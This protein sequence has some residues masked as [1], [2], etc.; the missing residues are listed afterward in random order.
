MNT[1]MTLKTLVTLAAAALGAGASALVTDPSYE[2]QPLDTW[3]NVLGNWI[4]NTWGAEQGAIV[5][6]MSGVT[7]AQGVQMLK[8]DRIAG[9]SSQ[10][11]QVIDLTAYSALIDSGQAVLNLSALFNIEAGFAGAIGGV[12]VY[13]FTGPNQWGSH[14]DY[15][16]GSVTLDGS[17]PSWQ[18]A[19]A[20]K[21]LLAGTRWIVAEVYYVN[22]TVPQG[23]FG[24]VDSVRAEVVPEPA[25][26]L[27]LGAGLA[28]VARRRRLRA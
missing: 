3:G 22:Q 28:A 10:A 27:A 1:H 21:T 15:F 26:L 18:A 4:P 20:S 14:T 24:F 5:G 12:G 16:A 7:P 2:T 11:G 19:Q 23:E 8:L 13:T 9:V 17:A 25:T 6:A